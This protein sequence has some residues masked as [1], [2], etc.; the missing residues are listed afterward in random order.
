[1][2]QLIVKFKWLIHDFENIEIYEW[3]AQAIN[4]EFRRSSHVLEALEHCN[5]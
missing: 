2:R 3:G 1:M 5:V 4:S